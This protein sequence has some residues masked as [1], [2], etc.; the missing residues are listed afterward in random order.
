[1]MLTQTLS[2]E[3][4]DKLIALAKAEGADNL[5]KRLIAAL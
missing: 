2:K 5:M 1:M 3:D 4:A